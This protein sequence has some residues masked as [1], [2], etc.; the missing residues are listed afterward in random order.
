MLKR[1][2][3]ILDSISINDIYNIQLTILIL[4]K[5]LLGPFKSICDKNQRQ[6]SKFK[7]VAKRM[8]N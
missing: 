5:I 2:M 7:Y 3:S 6:V 8:I 1:N 4:K